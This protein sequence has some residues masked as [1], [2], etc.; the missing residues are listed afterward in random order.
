MNGNS[1]NLKKNTFGD[2]LTIIKP[3]ESAINGPNHSVYVR[4]QIRHFQASK[5]RLPVTFEEAWIY[6]LYSTH[7]VSTSELSPKVFL[8]ARCVSKSEG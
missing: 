4:D 3:Y 1:H 8:P 2:D 5:S 6:S 7:N